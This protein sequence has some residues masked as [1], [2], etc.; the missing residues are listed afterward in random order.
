M[1]FLR[2]QEYPSG[3]VIEFPA[4]AGMTLFI[5]DSFIKNL[6]SIS[7]IGSFERGLG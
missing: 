2:M 7:A 1:S 3:A 5:V 4:Y 6:Y